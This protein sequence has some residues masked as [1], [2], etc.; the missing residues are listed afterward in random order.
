MRHRIKSEGKLGAKRH[1]YLLYALCVEFPPVRPV[2][3]TQRD[4]PH[5]G[6]AGEA[7]KPALPGPR[8]YYAACISS[9]A[10]S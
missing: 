5:R 2:D 6:E 4:T 9:S 7:G 8:Q 1:V 10:S 3:E